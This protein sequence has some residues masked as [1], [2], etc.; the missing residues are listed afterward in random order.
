MMNRLT[1]LSSL[2]YVTLL[3]TGCGLQSL[4]SGLDPEARLVTLDDSGAK[5]LCETAADAIEVLGRDICVSVG[6]ATIDAGEASCNEALVACTS[7]TEQDLEGQIEATKASCEALSAAEVVGASCDATVAEWEGCLN[8][9]VQA[10]SDAM[11][12][13]SCA[14]DP[15]EATEPLAMP[16]CEGYSAKGCTTPLA[17]SGV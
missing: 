11:A 7:S 10:L 9:Q 14:D 16:I 1:L 15:E 5:A 12:R 3:M 2:F 17:S 6:M 4:S 8:A 13:F